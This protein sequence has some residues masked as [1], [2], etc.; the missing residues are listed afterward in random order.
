VTVVYD[1]TPLLLRSAGVKNYHHSL[2]I[3]L[4]PRMRPHR[5]E[6]FPFL[7]SVGRNRHERSNFS[8]WATVPRL[9]AVL[10]A[11]YLRLPLGWWAARRADLFH[12]TPHL[13]HPPYSRVRITSFV[14]DPT[15][16]LMPE[17]HTASNVRYFRHFAKEVLP[18]LA[19]VIVPSHAVKRDLVEKL[20]VQEDKVAVIHHGV[21]QEFFPAGPLEPER[22][23]FDLPERYILFL[24][25]MEPRK[26]LATL[27]EAYRQLPEELRREYPLIVAGASGW[28]NR[29][30]RA[31]LERE[32]ARG[33]RS[34]GYVPPQA[35]PLVYG[36][37]SVFVFPSLY[38][39]FGM[40]LLEAMAAGAPVVTSNVSAMPEVVG[41]TGLIVDPKSPAELAAAIERVLA[42][43][44]LRAALSEKG[45]QRA[46]EFT[47]EKTAIATRQ[48][49][50]RVAGKC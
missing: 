36:G 45:R 10:A 2:L 30:L 3:R 47:W 43:R 24:G 46:R 31:E 21:D 39:G 16:L 17:F 40:P 35:L 19:G 9:G 41:D 14:H 28:K 18:R 15:C 26:N 50:E 12:V 34:L 49:F 23:A 42:D 27:L 6:L 29:K 48:F 22:R 13:Q 33:V 1:A 8:R 7:S 11:N 37:A 5:I 20:S 25:A 38:E 32:K 44:D 4:L